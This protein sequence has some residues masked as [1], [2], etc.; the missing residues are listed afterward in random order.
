MKTLYLHIGMAKTATT[1]V[2]N[3]C[4]DNQSLLMQKGYYY[5][6]FPITYPY[7]APQRNGHFLFGHLFNE[8]GKRD[9]QL[10]LRQRNSAFSHIYKQF[11]TYDNIVLSD[12]SLWNRGIT[13]DFNVWEFLKKEM[14]QHHFTVKIVVYLRRQDEYLY[15]WWGQRI[16]GGYRNEKTFTWEEMLEKMPRVKLDYYKMLETISSY[17]GKKNIILRRFGHQYFVNHSIYDDFLDAIGLKFSDEYVIKQEYLNKSLS[18]NNIEIR[19]ILN[20]LSYTNTLESYAFRNTLLDLSSMKKGNPNV[21]IYSINEAK[22]LLQ[23]YDESNNQVA[24]EYLGINEPLFEFEFNQTEKW[25]SLTREMLEDVI[26]FTGQELLNLKREL[27]A[28]NKLIEQQ[29]KQLNYLQSII[30]HPLKAARRKAM[31]KF[32]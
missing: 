9:K 27:A 29:Q 23:K 30:Q 21:S 2:Q 15:S 22:A 28:T 8:N 6:L 18:I 31:K 24:K 1:S 7:T 20:H 12:E 5:P 17:I 19:R 16:K 14:E 26:L 10:E 25:T 4:A 11:E 13:N 32:K 3:L